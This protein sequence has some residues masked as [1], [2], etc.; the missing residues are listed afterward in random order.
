MNSSGGTTGAEE[1]DGEAGLLE[2]DAQDRA[3]DDVGVV[4]DGAEDDDGLAIETRHQ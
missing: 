1:H 2:R 4:A 3:A